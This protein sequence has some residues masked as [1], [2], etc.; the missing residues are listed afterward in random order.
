MTQLEQKQKEL[1]E[2]LTKEITPLIALAY[3]EKFD[4]SWTEQVKELK[5]EIAELEKEDKPLIKW[6]EEK[7]DECNKQWEE[8]ASSGHQLMKMAFKEVKQYI[9]SL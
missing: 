8:T 9:E 5:S 7:I 3:E 2:L 1:I 6:V 4:L